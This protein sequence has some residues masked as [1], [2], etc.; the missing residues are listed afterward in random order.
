MNSYSQMQQYPQRE[1]QQVSYKHRTPHAEH[2]QHSPDTGSQ[3]LPPSAAA[4]APPL[5][6]PPELP[7]GE[8]SSRATP[9]CT[10][11][12]EEEQQV[13]YHHRTPH[14]QH[15][16]HSPDS[17]DLCL[18]PSPAAAAPSL[19]VPGELPYGEPSSHSTPISINTPR[20]KSSR[21]V[22][23]V[24]HMHSTDSTHL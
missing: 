10:N 2:G 19:G 23:T 16:Q 3:R 8:L 13:S 15:R 17:I 14:A 22:T 1:E 12:Q 6:V 4:A 9:R 5:G 18:P 24:S 11:T 21:L 7:Y 20:K